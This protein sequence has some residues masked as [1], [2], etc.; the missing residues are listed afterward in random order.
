[1]N[2]SE[3]LQATEL[4]CL[5]RNAK[6]SDVIEAFLGWLTEMRDKQKKAWE[7]VQEE[8]SKV[9]DFLHE[10]E[11]ENN[12]KKRAVIST[13]L[14]ESRRKRRDSKDLW[15]KLK[16]LSEFVR[17]A[18]NRNLIKMMKQL[19]VDLKAAEDFVNSERVYKPRVKEGGADGDNN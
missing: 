19:K 12:S 10:M 17:E 1:M 15:Q 9:Q 6:A 16:P 13:R 11:F 7:V 8:D 5:M 3:R 14:H 4:L 2:L 18:T